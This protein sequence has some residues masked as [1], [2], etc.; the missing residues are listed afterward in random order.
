MAL[1]KSNSSNRSS[2]GFSLVEVVIAMGI[3]TAVSLGVAQLFAA[4]GRSNLTARGVTS[5]TAMAEQK[6]E[7]IRS[8]T[9]GFD[10]AGQGLPL[11]D[12]STNLPRG[13]TTKP[14][15]YTFVRWRGWELAWRCWS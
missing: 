9:W 12:T 1:E 7:Q 13:F 14:A 6:M 4:T 2:A 15:M 10:L 5:T 8:L 3:L 11:T